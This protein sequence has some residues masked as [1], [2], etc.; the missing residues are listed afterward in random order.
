MRKVD[1][2]LPPLS[3]IFM[4]EE[5]D[6]IPAFFKEA[7]A[8]YP[9]KIIEIIPFWNILGKGRDTPGVKYLWNGNE[10]IYYDGIN[11]NKFDGK[12]LNNYLSKTYEE[13]KK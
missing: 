4:N 10:I 11:D 5:A 1:A 13:L 2:S 12:S 9:Y 6:L 7:G 8:N 3:I